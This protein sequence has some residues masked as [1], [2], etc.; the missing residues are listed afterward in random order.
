[1][2]LGNKNNLNIIKKYCLVDGGCPKLAKCKDYTERVKVCS[3]C[4]DKVYKYDMVEILRELYATPTSPPK[5]TPPRTGK[6]TELSDREIKDVLLLYRQGNSINKVSE[7]LHL[8]FRTVKNVINKSFK[9][10]SSNRK[11][12]KNEKELDKLKKN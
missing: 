8:Q 5:P 11:V 2:D 7:E 3:Q 6:G 4:I 1:M 12:E 9:N 10:E